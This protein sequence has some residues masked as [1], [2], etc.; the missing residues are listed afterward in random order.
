MFILAHSCPLAIISNK[1][2]IHGLSTLSYTFCDFSSWY[3]FFF[4][5]GT[6]FFVSEVHM[7]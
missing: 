2:R 1:M 7:T 3:P 4:K 6:F 5:M